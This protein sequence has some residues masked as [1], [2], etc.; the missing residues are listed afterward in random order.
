MILAVALFCGLGAVM[1]KNNSESIQSMMDS[2]GD[3]VAGFVTK[4]SADYF[5]IFDFSDFELTFF[6]PIPLSLEHLVRG[7]RAVP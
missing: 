6:Y 2:K 7:G 3:A 5:A 1:A 4:V